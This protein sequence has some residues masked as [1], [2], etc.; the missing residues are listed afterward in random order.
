MYFSPQFSTIL[1]N[2]YRFVH[3]FL[4][5]RVFGSFSPFIGKSLEGGFHPVSAPSSHLLI[6]VNNFSE[7]LS[8]IH[9][10]CK[11][12]A[13]QHSESGHLGAQNGRFQPLIWPLL[14]VN[15]AHI[16]T[17]Y[18]PSC[19]CGSGEALIATGAVRGYSH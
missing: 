7:I 15:M 13:H 4:F 9:D 19:F 5:L 18:I 17:L 2:F 3:L 11:L 10:I 12:C 6:P 1:H 8:K 14:R 16:A